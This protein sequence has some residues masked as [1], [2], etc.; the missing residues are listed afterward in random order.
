MQKNLRCNRR[1][2]GKSWLWSSDCSGEPPIMFCL[3]DLTALPLAFGQVKKSAPTL[4]QCVLRDWGYWQQGGLGMPATLPE[5]VSGAWEKWRQ[6]YQNGF[7]IFTKKRN[8][9]LLGCFPGYFW[10]TENMLLAKRQKLPPS[11]VL[12]TKIQWRNG[13]EIIWEFES[14]Q[15]ETE[16]V[17]QKTA[18]ATIIRLL[19]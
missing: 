18:H 9:C 6:T 5:K 2:K 7:T 8:P 13:T 4:W 14:S 19:D 12:A 15:T 16:T 1:K 3:N 17:F 10:R 11:S